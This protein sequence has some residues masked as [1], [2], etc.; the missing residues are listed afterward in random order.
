[1]HK[2]KRPSIL[3]KQNE[4]F[5]RHGNQSPFNNG[6]MIAFVFKKSHDIFRTFLVALISENVMV[7][8]YEAC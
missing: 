8:Y 6:Y 4:H 5:Y 2:I 1:M 7:L 3:I